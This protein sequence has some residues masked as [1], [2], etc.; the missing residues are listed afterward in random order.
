MRNNISRGVFKK[1]CKKF[2]IEKKKKKITCEY[3]LYHERF[4]RKNK[5][6]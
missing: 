2:G 6:E 4:K 1:K 5:K 3:T